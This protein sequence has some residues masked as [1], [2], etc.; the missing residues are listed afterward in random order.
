MRASRVVA[1]TLTLCVAGCS[2][3]R[4][5]TRDAAADAAAVSG[6]ADAA[7]PSCKQGCGPQHI[8]S[9]ADSKDC[10]SA[11]G[12]CRSV[13]SSCDPNGINAVCSCERRTYLSICEAHAAGASILHDGPC[14]A[15][16]CVGIGGRVVILPTPVPICKDH[17]AQ[18]GFVVGDDGAIFFEGA[19]CCL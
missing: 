11:S 17:E 10:A 9:Y 2:K 16:E 15:S 14:T 12:E 6:D 4:E 18:H 1:L 5:P 8:C 13:P 7:V 3:A 19:I